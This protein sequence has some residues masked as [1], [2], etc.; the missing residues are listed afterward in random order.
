MT[1]DVVVRMRGRTRPRVA[2]PLGSMLIL[3]L[4][5]IA[6]WLFGRHEAAK[7]MDAWIGSEEAQGRSWTC[8][9]REIAG[10]PLRIRIAC[11]SPTF[12]GK[13][14]GA[15][16]EASL[17]DFQAE[18]LI[19]QPNAV[20]ASATGPLTVH[21]QD[22]G[23]DTRLAWSALNV[24]FRGLAAD[25]KRAALVI[26]GPDLKLP[27]GTGG[28]ADRIDIRIAPA[29]GRRPDEN[30]YDVWLTLG[31]GLIPAL[32]TLTGTQEPLAVEEKGVL[33]RLDPTRVA[34]WQDLAE[35]WRQ[36]GGAFEL[37]M[38]KIS[39]GRLNID[40]QGSLGLDDAHRPAGR[41]KA[42]MSGYETLAAQLGIPLRAVSVGG[43]LAQ[44]LN[45]NGAV[46]PPGEPGGSGVNLPVVFADGR[47]LIG[48][49]KTGL[50]LPPLY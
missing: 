19:Y 43:V 39:K 16:V 4:G 50:R 17:T 22:G 1:H 11:T 8:P 34:P 28:R 37:A 13:L 20:E 2:L 23:P 21:E 27:D 41:L 5:W 38:L 25:R 35:T 44:L 26:D 10:F 49:F 45:R 6:L 18:T 24:T 15:I 40:A 36:A 46:P 47:V 42:A 12:R 32:D 29:A 14:G 30:A 48:P 33:T 31:N 3:V 7:E 9:D